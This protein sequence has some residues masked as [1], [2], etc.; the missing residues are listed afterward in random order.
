[1]NVRAFSSCLWLI[2]LWFFLGPDCWNLWSV[3]L[4]IVTQSPVRWLVGKVVCVSEFVVKRICV[5]GKARSKYKFRQTL[6]WRY[7]SKCPS[8]V[9]LVNK[10]GPYQ[11]YT[12]YFSCLSL[13]LYLGEAKG[14]QSTLNHLGCMWDLWNTMQ[15]HMLLVVFHSIID[16]GFISSLHNWDD[17]MLHILRSSFPCMLGHLE[18][19][20]GNLSLSLIHSPLHVEHKCM[21]DAHTY[22]VYNLPWSCWVAVCDTA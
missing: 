21:H 20:T 17:E 12:V 13:E 7:I 14:S 19:A 2:L 15:T 16:T 11:L 4:F 3:V 22:T 9:K 18:D 6:F 8:G 5:S 10:Y 1:M